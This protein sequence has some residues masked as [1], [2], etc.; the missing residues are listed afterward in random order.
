MRTLI[1]ALILTNL[2][3]FA[4]ATWQ[5]SE[6]QQITKQAA[7]LY[8]AN[9]VNDHAATECAERTGYRY[10]CADGTQKASCE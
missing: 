4:L 7:A 8:Y 10:N 6:V 9:Y 3:W 2:A 1:A 5:A